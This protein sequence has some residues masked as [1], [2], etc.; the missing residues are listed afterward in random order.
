MSAEFTPLTLIQKGENIAK[1]VDSKSSE[2][3]KKQIGPKICETIEVQDSKV[4]KQVIGESE[5]SKSEKIP[6]K[7]YDTEGNPDNGLD[8]PSKILKRE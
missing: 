5:T 1:P 8:K 2:E 6:S 4:V 7:E 3:D